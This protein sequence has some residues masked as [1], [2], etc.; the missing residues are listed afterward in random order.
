MAWSTTI[1][2][3]LRSDLR[4]AI[5]AL[6][7]V[8]YSQ[9]PAVNAIHSAIAFANRMV[10]P[11]RTK[12]RVMSETD[13]ALLV[14][15]AKTPRDRLLLQVLYA[16][17]LRVSELVTLTWSDVIERDGGKVQLSV[18][19]KGSVPRDVLLPDLVSKSLLAFRGEA[20]ADDA[21]F[22]SRWT[23]KAI[24]TRGVHDMIKKTAERAGI[25]PAVSAHW[26][27]HGHASHALDR[28]ATLADVQATLGHANV[29]TTSSYLHSRPDRSSGLKLDEGVWF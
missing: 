22:K 6:T 7:C 15:A 4:E 19:G 14:R 3:L 25:N 13:V 23:D 8:K 12:Q 20:S 24:T 29:A 16:A 5:N 11:S 2:V 26:L 17:G 27:R 21:V 9:S 18:M 10:E 28:G 1:S